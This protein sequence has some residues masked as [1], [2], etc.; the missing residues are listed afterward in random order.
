MAAPH[1]PGFEIIGERAADI[2]SRP[3]TLVV[4]GVSR[5]GT[6]A[7]AGILSQLGVYMGNSGKAPM[8]EDLYLNRAVL[9]GAEDD[10]RERL[11]S[12]NRAQEVWGYKGVVLNRDLERY[13]G[14]FRSPLYLVVYR[15]LLA[16]AS[17]ARLSAGHEVTA[18]ISRQLNEYRRILRF[19]TEVNPPAMLLSYEKLILEPRPLVEKIM[20]FTGLAGDEDAV[21]QAA[22]SVVTRPESYPQVFP[23][24]PDTGE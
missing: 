10:F 17:R 1:N 9:N 16:I 21:A 2:D 12:Y 7:T 6:S 23:Q 18:I 13:H 5:G 3:R 19:L 11:A 4:L 20:E 24:P 14:L 15:D 8:Y 22:S